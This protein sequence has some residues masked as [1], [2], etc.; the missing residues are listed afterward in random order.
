MGALEQLFPDQDAIKEQEEVA[1]EGRRIGSLIDVTENWYK[2][3]RAR[4]DVRNLSYWRGNFWRG[5]GYN[6]SYADKATT[7]YTAQQNETFPVIDTIVSSLAMDVPQI[8]AIDQRYRS[9]APPTRTGDL[10][11]AGRRHAAVLNYWAEEDC[12]DDA[13]REWILHAELFGIGVL[14]T[15][16]SP[17]LKRPIFRT[18]L[19]W[20]FFYD[21]SAKRPSDMGWCYEHFVLHQDDFKARV[22]D[23]TYDLFSRPIASDTYPRTL[24]D[25]ELGDDDEMKL[26]NDGL[27]EYVALVEFWDF[28]RQKLVHFHPGSKQ[29]VCIV[30]MPYSRPYDVLVFHDAIGQIRGLSDVSLLAPNQKDVNIMVSA[31]REMVF[32]LQQRIV[33]DAEMFEDDQEWD[34][35]KDAKPWEPQKARF[36]NVSDPSQRVWVWPAANT[37]VDFGKHLEQTTDSGRFTVGLAD[38]QRGEVANIRTAAEATMVRASTEGRINRRVKKVVRGITSVFKRTDEVWRWAIDHEEESGIDMEEIAFLTQADSDADQLMEDVLQGAPRFRILPFSPLMEDKYARREQLTQL[39]G[40]LSGNQIL[41][42]ALDPF[43]TMREV[44]ELYGARPSCI[45]EPPPP[46]PPPIPGADVNQA[47][48]A[49]MPPEL[50]ALTPGSPPALAV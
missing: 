18:R 39:L 19:P 35:I 34:R 33:F 46:A 44:F 14:K 40:N 13:V 15:S 47:P 43:E 3:E 32:R 48:I 4:E 7:E 1:R 6:P 22:E 50:P 5:D 49:G 11:I 17:I 36:G 20:E 31:R 25:D 8:E 37:S 28:R 24:V 29:I 21:Q 26:R 38:F 30:D 2:R 45:R 16:W 12:L 42:E 27:R 23:D 41:M 10:N 9:G